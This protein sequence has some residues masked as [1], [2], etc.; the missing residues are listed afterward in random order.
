MKMTKDLYDYI[1]ICIHET[2]LTVGAEKTQT[3]RDTVQ[4][5]KDQFTA[6]AWGVYRV[7]NN[8]NSFQLGDMARE[9]GLH[10]SHIETAIKKILKKYK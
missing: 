4:Y 8:Q 5:T 3:F 9:Q 1:D 2:I 6:F 10:D 7:A